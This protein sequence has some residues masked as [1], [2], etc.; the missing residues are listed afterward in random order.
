MPTQPYREL[1]VIEVAD[2]DLNQHN[3]LLMIDMID[4]NACAMG[5][6]I[7]RQNCLERRFAFEHSDGSRTEIRFSPHNGF[8][9]KIGNEDASERH[10]IIR[11]CR[12]LLVV[13]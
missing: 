1:G 4:Q 13:G 9:G 11:R 2:S 12:W 6:F 8:R 5:F 7:Y 10:L 3:T